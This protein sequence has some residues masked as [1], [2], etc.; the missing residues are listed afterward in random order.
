MLAIDNGAAIAEDPT[1]AVMAAVAWTVWGVIAIGIVIAL[2]RYGRRPFVTV[3]AALA[4]GGLAATAFTAAGNEAVRELA[5]KLGSQD[6]V[7]TYYASVGAPIIEE[8]LKVAGIVGLALIPRVR[9]RGPLDGLFWGALVGAGFQVVENFFYTMNFMSSASGP[10]EAIGSM[11]FIRG[12]LSGLFTHAV[13]GA[14]EGAAIGYAFSRRNLPAWR[15][16]LVV[17]AAV[18]L[19]LII[20]GLGN[21]QNEGTLLVFAIGAVPLGTTIVLIIW[22]RRDEARRLAELAPVALERGLMAT[23]EA[24]ALRADSRAPGDKAAKRRR[25]AQLRYLYA[26]DDAGPDDPGAVELAERIPAAGSA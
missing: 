14:V 23:E 25:L 9:L 13:F 21:A 12:F 10:V 5:A 18:A 15:R 17:L 11:L 2:Q 6:L 19:V 16:V 8:S 24:D 7:E 3:I 20:H 22:A 4:W 26:V 1:G